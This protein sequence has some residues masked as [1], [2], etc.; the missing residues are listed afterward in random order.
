MLWESLASARPL[1]GLLWAH[2]VRSSFVLRHALGVFA[3]LGG[4]ELGHPDLAVPSTHGQRGVAAV[5]EELG[6]EDSKRRGGFQRRGRGLRTRGWKRDETGEDARA[7]PLPDPS[8]PRLLRSAGSDRKASAP[9]AEL[10]QRSPRSCRVHTESRQPGGDAGGAGVPP[11][12]GCAVA[13]AEPVPPGPSGGGRAIAL[14]THRAFCHAT[15]PL[16]RPPAHGRSQTCCSPGPEELRWPELGLGRLCRARGTSTHHR[17]P[18]LGKMVDFRAHQWVLMVSYHPTAAGLLPQPFAVMTHFFPTQH[19]PAEPMCF[20]SRHLPTAGDLG[21]PSP[22]R[23][24]PA[25]SSPG[26][27]C[28]CGRSRTPAPAAS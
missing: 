18:G 22:P 5:G 7:A 26:R 4:R 24:L 9:R 17:Q 28:S 19:R 14:P 16:A 12:A 3:A 27:R 11:S 1:R 20:Q 23:S 21:P 6:L 13:A 25:P 15:A 2:L 8:K 10:S